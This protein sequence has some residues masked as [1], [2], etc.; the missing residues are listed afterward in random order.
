[1]LFSLSLCLDLGV[2]GTVPLAERTPNLRA[3]NIVLLRPTP[4][5]PS[6]GLGV[7]PAAFPRQAA[8]RRIAM[9]DLRRGGH[10]A[11][12]LRFAGDLSEFHRRRQHVKAPEGPSP[13]P[14]E[15]MSSE[16][17][18]AEQGGPQTLR[19]GNELGRPS[20]PSRVLWSPS[21]IGW[22]R[23]GVRARASIPRRSFR[24]GGAS[25]SLRLTSAFHTRGVRAGH[26]LPYSARMAPSAH[27]SFSVFTF[28]LFSFSVFTFQFFSF[29]PL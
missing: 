21:P 8:S 9:V 12:R 15:A 17:A 27:F 2:P 26:A 16:V 11:P 18:A 28:Q 5:K 3:C 1:M 25:G 14:P 10:R 13:L 6:S 29:S 7:A 23:V 22:E 24:Q 4:A 20:S 19:R